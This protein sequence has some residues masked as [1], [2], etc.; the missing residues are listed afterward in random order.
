MNDK[1]HQMNKKMLKYE[2]A[3]SAAANSN[4]GGDQQNIPSFGPQVIVQSK[5]EKQLWKQISVGFL[6]YSIYCP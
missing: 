1:S 2:I 5:D 3:N 6:I 4:I